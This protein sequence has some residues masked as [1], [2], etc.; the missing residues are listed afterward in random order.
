MPLSAQQTR[1]VQ[2]YLLDLN[3]TQAYIKAGYAEKGANSGGSRLLAH[4]EVKREIERRKAALAQRSEVTRDWLVHEL[5]A[6][7]EQARKG[8]EHFAPDGSL[9]SVT[10][11]PEAVTRLAELLAKM[12]GWIDDKPA[13]AQQLVNFVIQR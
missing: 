10:R 4:V 9:K 3:A 7:L 8:T 6:E 13:P 2:F 1:F 5:A 11:R 12:H